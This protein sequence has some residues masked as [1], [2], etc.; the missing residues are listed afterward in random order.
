MVELNSGGDDR[1]YIRYL[2]SGYDPAEPAPVVLDLTAYSPA[3]MEEAFSGWTTAG[4]DG[5]AKA[6]EIGAVVVTP[7][8]VNGAGLLTWN[9]D[10]TPGWTDDPS[11]LVDVLDDVAATACTDPDR[12]L[13]SGFAIGGVMASRFACDH[14]DRV[15]A[16]ATVSGLWDPSGCEPSRPVP[17][18]SFHGDDDHF[19]PY[20]GG[21]GDHVGELGL[22]PETSEGL[23]AMAERP[24]AAESSQSW[25][26]RNGCDAEPATA[27][28]PAGETRAWSNCTG[29]ATVALWTVTGGSHT[30]PGSTGMDPYEELLGP[31]N[32]EIDATDVIWSFFEEEV[33]GR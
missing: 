4:A 30:W 27:P 15:T 1:S 2:P 10:G 8:P 26:D 33:A 22:T 29:G 12:V 6:D 17:V 23:V 19:L 20:D 9:V 32:D 5:S 21:I 14:A 7:E 24:G 3:S 18:I 25:A 11:F 28:N 16:I 13:V 31:V